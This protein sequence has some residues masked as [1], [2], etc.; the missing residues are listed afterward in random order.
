MRGAGSAGSAVLEEV[1]DDDTI[2]GGRGGDARAGE[3]RI[4]PD[5]AATQR[6]LRPGGAD[7]L[8]C[9]CREDCLLRR[10]ARHGLRMQVAAS[11]PAV[12]P[13]ASIGTETLWL[14]FR[15][16]LRGFVARRISNPADVEDIV[17]WVF[18]QMHRHLGRIKAPEAIHAWLYRTARRAIAD[19]YRSGIRRREVLSGDAADLEALHAAAEQGEDADTRREV[20]DCLAPVVASLGPADREAIVLTELQGLRIADA[21]SRSGVSL[22]GMKSRVQR[23][24]RKLREAIFECC[25][26][27]LDGR[28]AP[29]GCAQ[30][31]RR[32]G[33]CCE[34]PAS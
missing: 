20:A 27:A 21:A 30:R 8:L 29:I 13:L 34:K 5:T 18:L 14:E 19:H 31:D 4:R 6:M 32:A 1:P 26:F 2:A 22:S 12:Q 10:I 3:A 17:Q 23:A 7:R 24:R 33:P 16:R 11:P 28:G 9:A 25:D 15:E